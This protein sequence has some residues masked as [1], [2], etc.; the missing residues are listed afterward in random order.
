MRSFLLF[1]LLLLVSVRLLAQ[2]PATAPTTGYTQTVRGQVLDQASNAPLVGASVILLDSLLKLGTFTDDEGRFELA[3]VPLG[4][5]AFLVRYVGYEDQPISNLNVISGKQ[6]QLNITMREKVVTSAEVQIT[7]ESDKSKTLNNTASV[8]AR[9]FSLDEANR[10]AGAL[11]DPSRMVRSY[12]GVTNA[13]DDRND[14]VIRGNSPTGLLWRLEGVDIFNPNHFSSQGANGGP[15]GMLNNNMLANSDFF[16]SAFPA[17]YGNATSGAF[18]IKLRNGNSQ[19]FETLFQLGFAGLEAMV[20]GPF[21]KKRNQSFAIAYRYSSLAIFSLLGARYGE[22]NAVPYFQDLNFKVNLPAGKAGTFT[23]FGVGGLSSIDIL[24]SKLKPKEVETLQRTLDYSDVRLVS[25]MGTMGISHS[26]TLGSKT[27]M[28]TTFATMAEYRTQKF[29]TIDPTTRNVAPNYGS[30]YLNLK[31]A[32]VWTLNH[33]FNSRHSIRVGTMQDIYTLQTKDSIYQRQDSAFFTLRDVRQTA[34]LSRIYVNWQFRITEALTLNAGVYGQV[35]SLNGKVAADP[36]IGLRYNVRPKHT[37]SI[38]YGLN[39]QL[40]NLLLYVLKDNQ[41]QQTNRDMGF[42]RAHH[43]VL[44]YDYQ[45]LP[46]LRLKAEAYYQY[47][48]NV[49]VESTPSTFSS[50]NL[51]ANFNNLPNLS[52]LVNK[53]AGQ[54]YGLEITLEKFFNKNYYVLL[55]A[56]LYDS[57]Y[58]A[59]DGKWRSTAF[60]GNYVVNALAG[61][62]IALGKRKAS[63]LF[64]DLQLSLAGGQRYTPVDTAAS[65]QAGTGVEDNTRPFAGQGPLYFRMDVKIGYRRN[66]KKFSLEAAFQAQNITF[67]QNLFRRSWNPV[68]NQ[69]VNRYQQGFFP[70]G[71][72]RVYF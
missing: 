22:L 55:T 2:A 69:E 48:D 9:S 11:G 64:A 27:Y 44:G 59:S 12:A 68:L 29:D 53:G 21:S 23:I 72:F 24:E 15:I 8:S 4:R 33:K 35:F 49:P 20:E 63:I 40:Q 13:N 67:N 52:N 37:L 18:D 39:H 71:I 16:T 17:E 54:N 6:T 58:R 61:G 60:N 14:I 7:A 28:K 38:G 30:R 50:L 51:G 36:R 70:I 56:S 66:F 41:G 25:M 10:Y 47:L 43:V 65:R 45:I 26:I 19:K 5:R 32:L 31:Q 42:T 34:L 62:E 46:N 3:N 1:L 57:R